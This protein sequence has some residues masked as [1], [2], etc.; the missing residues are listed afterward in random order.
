MGKLAIYE[1]AK[2]SGHRVS[3]MADLESKPDFCP[4][5]KLLQVY[6]DL[7]GQLV[8]G[9]GGAFTQAAAIAYGNMGQDIQK[10]AMALTFGKE[11]LA[12]NSGRIPIAACDF[13]EGNY[14][15]CD[16]KDDTELKSFSLKRDQD[17]VFPL[18]KQAMVYCPDLELLAS[19]WSPPAWM[20]DNGDMCHG[21]VLKKEYYS[22]YARYLAKY[23]RQCRDQG[24]PVEM[25]TVQNEPHA[26]QT[27]ES[28]IYSAED[29]TSFIQEHLIP[30]LQKEGAEAIKLLIWD[31]NKD[32][33]F[34]RAEEMLR[35]EQMRRY[36]SGIAFHWYSG[37]HFENIAL[38]RKHFP[39]LD[40]VFSEGCVELTATETA[41]AEKAM[42]V[43]GIREAGVGAWE[44]GEIYAHDII[45]NFNS[46]MNRFLDWNMF[47]DAQGGPNHVG[48]YCSAPIM[49]D[50]RRQT[51]LLQPSY[52][53]IKHFSAFVPRGSRVVAIS[54]YT[55]ALEAVAFKRP[56]GAI[57]AVMMN[58]TKHSLQAN[59]SLV[60]EGQIWHLEMK[61]KSIVTAIYEP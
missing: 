38:C 52:F 27:W 46:G 10:R 34:L 18:I 8:H 54:R 56:D 21:G 44:F 41:V 45:G 29:E 31:H 53:Y 11:G 14:S 16:L 28:C 59:L 48:N 2:D 6:S 5:M 50:A 32:L 1:S 22:V 19:P 12:Y 23:L 33:A 49:L 15:Y 3:R 40:L 13:S 47:L 9:F 20:K 36:V 35:N 25:L 7:E 43:G 51:I 55:S 24:I 4:E 58:A 17:R 61:P 57:V 60:R 37:D 26:V 42:A 30:A 39:T